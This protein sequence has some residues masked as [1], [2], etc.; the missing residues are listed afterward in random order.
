MSTIRTRADIEAAIEDG[1]LPEWEARRYRSF[2]RTMT[3]EESPY[4]CYFAVDA[5]EAGDLR[6]LFAPPVATEAGRAAVAD[7]L[8]DYLAAAP[9][10]ADLT[11]LAVFFEPS[12]GADATV[13][14]VREDVWGLLR[15][16]RRH[17]PEP[18]PQDVPA[19]PENPEWEFCFAG[20]PMFLVARAPAYE[21]RHSRHTPHGVEV[22]VQPRWV[23]DD[24]GGDTPAGR[25]ARGRIRERLSAYDDVPVS[26]EVGD[27][28]DEGS[29]EWK[30]YVL[31]DGDEPHPDEFPIDGWT[32]DP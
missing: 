15:Y 25:A 4:P 11:A 12:D 29:R 5:H 9:D 14:E 19:D 8:A 3:D 17:D 13:P 2:D 7:G 32:R 16:L 24:F 22:T 18:W 20:E 6:Y 27:Y 26:P 1:S 28:A 31:P 21:R 10:I 23:F 30:Q